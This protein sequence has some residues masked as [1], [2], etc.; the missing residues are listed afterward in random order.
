MIS[1]SYINLLNKIIY[2]IMI[3]DTAQSLNNEFNFIT[4]GGSSCESVVL[5]SLVNKRWMQ[6]NL[7][8][9]FAMCSGMKRRV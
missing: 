7:Y 2:Q 8:I 1:D 4:C 6:S 9:N 5:C 3:K